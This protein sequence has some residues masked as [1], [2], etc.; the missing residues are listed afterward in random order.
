MTDDGVRAA[1]QERVVGIIHVQRERPAL[2]MTGVK[3]SH[4]RLADGL[5]VPDLGPEA[6]VVQF[7]R[8]GGKGDNA[9]GDASGELRQAPVHAG[10]I[11]L[12]Q[13]RAEQRERM[14]DQDV[15]LADAEDRCG[16]GS[17]TSRRYTSRTAKAASM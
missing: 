6:A 17:C 2:A 12:G 8:E 7:V 14:H 5:P 4:D 3:A 15:D 1:G 11:G 10:G 16:R 9:A 13:V